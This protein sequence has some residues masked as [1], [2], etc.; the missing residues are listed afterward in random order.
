VAIET[1]G[2]PLLVEGHAAA[3]AASI[4]KDSSDGEVKSADS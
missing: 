4:W 1:A 3:G 2:A